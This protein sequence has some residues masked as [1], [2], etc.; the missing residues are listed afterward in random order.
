MITG[1]GYDPV[2][3]RWTTIDPLAEKM[4]LYS[5]YSYAFNNPIRFIDVGGQ[6]PYPITVRAFHPDKYFGG[7]SGDNRGYTTAFATA[8]V[9]QKLLFDTDKSSLTSEAWS[10]KTHALYGAFESRATPKQE[11]TSFT[12]STSDDGAKHFGIQ[13]HVA[14][15]NP[16]APPGTP[17]VDVFSALSITSKD[18]TLSITGKLTGD[19]FP[20]TEAFVSDPSGQSVFL[21][22]GSKE[23]NPY[24]SLWG[25][26]KDN[27]ITNFSL[28]LT[29]DGK[30]NFIGVN[31]NGKTYSLTD[32]NKQFQ[33]QDPHKN[34]KRNE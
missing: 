33:Q 28:S 1:R 25:D 3:G 21:G 7:Y 11:I 27:Q 4:T 23:G 19:N 34:N 18:N 17:D 31:A 24:K 16:L 29:T 32:W 30:G 10:S 15:A 9:T 5:P 14:S 13:A 2:I 6:I 26:N 12:S 8:R 22:I 20:S